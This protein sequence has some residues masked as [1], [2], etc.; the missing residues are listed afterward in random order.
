MNRSSA[1]SE[2]TYAVV[3]DHKQMGSFLELFNVRNA[4]LT[5]QCRVIFTG[6]V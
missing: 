6:Q 5:N 1:V 3:V 2:P 4:S